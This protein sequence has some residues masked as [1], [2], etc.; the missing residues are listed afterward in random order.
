MA[1][2]AKRT[3]VLEGARA[4]SATVSIK[5]AAPA[6][7]L[8]LRAKADAVSEL[9]QALDI[10]LPQSPKTSTTSGLRAALW[11]GPDEWLVIDQGESNLMDACASV[12]APHSAT[13]VSHRNVAMTVSGEGAEATL[14]A[15]CPQALSLN[16]FPVGACSRTLFGKAEVVILRVAEDTFRVEC[17]RS[18]ADYVFGLLE[19]GARDVGA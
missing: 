6:Y 14:N 16:A 15:G 5:M 13:D 9:S 4:G 10:S 7:R 12:L 8:S 2:L 19:E 1:D 11:L 17:W 18:F 3:L